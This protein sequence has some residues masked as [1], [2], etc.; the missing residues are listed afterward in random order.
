MNTKIIT[1]LEKHVEKIVLAVALAGAGVIAWYGTQPTTLSS[2]PT[3]TAGTVED[4]V[5]KAVGDL[6]AARKATLAI[7]ESR[8]TSALHDYVAQYN[9]IMLHHP[10]SENL[11]ATTNMPRFGPEQEPLEGIVIIQDG[12]TRIADGTGYLRRRM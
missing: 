11:V 12:K 3:M 5:T 8:L 4:K 6:E 9:Q 7:P 1:L 2:D 10:L